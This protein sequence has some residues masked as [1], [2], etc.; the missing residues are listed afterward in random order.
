VHVSVR[1]ARSNLRALIERARAGEEIV[2]LRRGREVARL[3]PP[4]PE[5]SRFPDLSAFQ[6]S[7]ALAGEP[8]S[9]TVSHQRR[10]ARY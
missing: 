10:D 9:E 4:V 2:I 5:R 8:T 3:V 7:I 6:A 1:E